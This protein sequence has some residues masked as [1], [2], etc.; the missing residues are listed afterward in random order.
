MG[1]WR[2]G[3][4]G[5][6]LGRPSSFDSCA[7]RLERSTNLI[8]GWDQTAHSTVEGDG[9]TA[10]DCQPNVLDHLAG[11]QLHGQDAV[12]A[13]AESGQLTIGEGPECDRPE[14]SDPNALLASL[15]NRTASDAG[16]RAVGHDRELGIVELPAFPADLAPGDLAVLVLQGQVSRLEHLRHQ[17]YRLDD[18]GQPTGWARQ[19]PIEG[20][21]FRRAESQLDRF[22]RLAEDPVGQAME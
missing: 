5:V 20:V 3:N 1:A 18:P 16:S 4:V 2:R 13:P 22:H 11:R 21:A 14:E 6:M 7:E 19:R 8:R 9:A 15:G 17:V 10:L 12:Q